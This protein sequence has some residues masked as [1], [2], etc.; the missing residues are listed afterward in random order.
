MAVSC[1]AQQS[2][3][4]R[5]KAG[6]VLD[7]ATGKPAS[8]APGDLSPVRINNRVRRAIDAALGGLTLLSPDP[9]R[10]LD[11]ARAVFKSKDANALQRFTAIKRD[12]PDHSAGAGEARAAV[13]CS[14][15]THRG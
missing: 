12:Q 11:A 8:A 7:A 13:S 2:S 4:F 9:A 5:D 15:L 1:S 10:R 6:A 3:S 14:S